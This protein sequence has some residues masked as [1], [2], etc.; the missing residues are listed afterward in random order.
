MKSLEI[1]QILFLIFIFLAFLL[2]ISALIYT[3]SAFSETMY[4]EAG[5]EEGAAKKN[6]LQFQDDVIVKADERIDG[7]VFVR[8]G[9]VIIKGKIY[10]D[11]LV[12]DGDIEIDA[13]AEIY[14][15]VICYDGMVDYDEQAMLGGDIIRIED[16]D[17]HI[18]KM[19]KFNS[20]KFDYALYHQKDKM[21]VAKEETIYGDLIFVENDGDI[22]GKV[23]GDLFIISGNISISADAA[24]DGHCINYAGT[25]SR[26]DEALIT[27]M[28][29]DEHDEG[30]ELVVY[31]DEEEDDLIRDEVENKYLRRRNYTDEDVVRFFGDVIIEEDE[32][33]DGDVVI[34]KGS[35]HLKGEVDGDIVAIFG[36]IKLDS[37]GYVRGDVVSV[38]GKIFRDEGSYVGGDVVQTTW[39]GVRVNEPDREYEDQDDDK[40]DHWEWDRWRDKYRTRWNDEDYEEDMENGLVRYN[41]VEGLFLGLQVPNNQWYTHSRHH[42]KIYGHAGYGFKSK[43]GRYQIGLER[44]IFDDFRFTLGIETHDMTDTEDRWI[45]SEFENSLAAFF[46]REDF[47]DYYR[48]YGTSVY[49][50]QNITRHFRVKGGIRR[51]RFY[52]MEKKTNWSLFGGDKKFHENPAVEE[53][54]M[55]SVFGHV[56]LDTRNHLFNPNEGW[57]ININGEFVRP[58]INKYS[59]HDFDRLIIDLRRYQPIGYGENLD[60]R[61]RL[62]TG[63]GKLPVQYQYDLG[64]LS[65]LRGYDFKE[66]ENGDRMVLGNIEYRMYGSFFDLFD[67]SELNLIIF[68]DAGWVWTAEDN[69]AFDKSFDHIRW[70]DMMTDVGIA[71]SNYEG[72]VRLSVAQRLDD[73]SHPVVVTFR[74]R[75]PF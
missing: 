60:F 5:T 6:L 3:S 65:S 12:V 30:T 71:L 13:T 53:F 24:V 54:E 61:F 64:G 10:G 74:I 52:S 69:S 17:V 42:V 32:R 56:G 58:D 38:G 68:G 73:R 4:A 40:W 8:E 59:E 75:Q 25:L 29:V 9:D 43:R 37:T 15:N 72:N 1:K 39:T 34:M 31:E 70:D 2:V 57:F 11:L 19:R 67:I 47:R 66:F 63:R 36:D 28:L 35:A 27:G 50:I 55:K 48:R 20:L 44:W 21:V 33:I 18:V 51:D 46:L 16:D 62:G 41:R 14:G 23:D 45:I 7:D 49:A 22:A 26:S